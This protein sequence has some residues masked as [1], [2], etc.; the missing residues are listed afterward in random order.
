[1]KVGPDLVLHGRHHALLAVVDGFGNPG[2]VG[3][4]AHGEV[5]LMVLGDYQTGQGLGYFL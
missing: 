3:V 2:H 1:M 5:A 4:R